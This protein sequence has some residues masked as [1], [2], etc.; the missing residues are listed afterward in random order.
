MVPAGIMIQGT[1]PD[2]YGEIRI[3]ARAARF[4]KRIHRRTRR[5]MRCHNIAAG[6]EGDDPCLRREDRLGQSPAELAVGQR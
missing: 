2:P 5:V 3:C 6:E 1:H 4:F